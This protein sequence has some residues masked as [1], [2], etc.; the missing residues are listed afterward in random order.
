[1]ALV[2]RGSP[3]SSRSQVRFS[4]AHNNFSSQTPSRSSAESLSRAYREASNYAN[5][6]IHLERFE[7]ARALLRKTVPVARRVLGKSHEGTITMR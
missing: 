1:M 6:L 4:I 2:L 5:T 3:P 7:E